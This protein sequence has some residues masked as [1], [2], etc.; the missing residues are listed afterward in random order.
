MKKD[1]ATIERPEFYCHNNKTTVHQKELIQS[2]CDNWDGLTNKLWLTVDGTVLLT[3]EKK[4][5]DNKGLQSMVSNTFQARLSKTVNS[6][7]NKTAKEHTKNT[8]LSMDVIKKE[9]G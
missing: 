1:K 9:E 7:N 4:E 6:S 3:K 5:K 8:L 2:I